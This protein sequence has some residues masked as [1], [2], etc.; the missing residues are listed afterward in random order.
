[1]A[2]ATATKLIRPLHDPTHSL[3]FPDVVKY[4]FPHLRL[5]PKS[6]RFDFSQPN[7]KSLNVECGNLGD[8]QFAKNFD[9]PASKVSFPNSSFT[10]Y[11]AFFPKYSVERLNWII[12]MVISRI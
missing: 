4:F 5:L 8:R 7:F 2:S 1:L 10:F 9:V 3:L 12:Q 6:P 11:P